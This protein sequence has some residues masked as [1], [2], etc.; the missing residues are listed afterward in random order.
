MANRIPDN[1][2]LQL[3]QQRRRIPSAPAVSSEGATIEPIAGPDITAGPITAPQQSSITSSSAESLINTQQPIPF[4][5]IHYSLPSIPDF[6]A[7]QVPGDLEQAEQFN[8]QIQ[9]LNNTPDVYS[10]GQLRNR[11]QSTFNLNRHSST[12]APTD[13]GLPSEIDVSIEQAN[14]RR[15]LQ[16]Q[17]A[18]VAPS[19]DRGLVGVARSLN[20]GQPFTSASNQSV[21]DFFLNTLGVDVAPVATERE[22]TEPTTMLDRVIAGAVNATSA[23]IPGAAGVIGQLVAPGADD[24]GAGRRIF[25]DAGRIAN[26]RI[27]RRIEEV[28]LGQFLSENTLGRITPGRTVEN[29]A[30]NIRRQYGT[31]SAAINS[32]IQNYTLGIGGFE[33]GRLVLGAGDV[34]TDREG[35]EPFESTDTTGVTSILSRVAGSTE[36]ESI[37]LPTDSSFIGELAN[38]SPDLRNLLRDLEPVVNEAGEIGFNP[39]SGHFGEFGSAGS[40]SGL[41]WLANLPE[42]VVTGALYDIADL[43][44]HVTYDT[45]VG[46]LLGRVSPIFNEQLPVD[47]ARRLDLLGA[48]VGRDYGF[49]Q[50]YTEDRYLSFIGNPGLRFI[51]KPAQIAAGFIAD[52][53]LGGFTDFALTDPVFDLITRGSRR[54]TQNVAEELVE[55]AT[56]V[57]RREV[58]DAV[59]RSVDDVLRRN[60][61]PEQIIERIDRTVNRVVADSAPIDRARVAV[62]DVDTAIRRFNLDSDTSFSLTTSIRRA[63]DAQLEIPFVRPSLVGEVAETIAPLTRRIDDV[64][65]SGERVTRRLRTLDEQVDRIQSLISSQAARR[66]STEIVAPADEVAEQLTLNYEQSLVNVLEEQTTLLRGASSQEI[67][68]YS[69]NLLRRAD[70]ITDNGFIIQENA[71]EVLDTLAPRISVEQITPRATDSTTELLFAYRSDP[72]SLNDLDVFSVRR[73]DQTVSEV[74]NLWGL[75]TPP[76]GDPSTPI[77]ELRNLYRSTSLEQRYPRLLGRYGK[78]ISTNIEAPIKRIDFSSQIDQPYT[79]SAIAQPRARTLPVVEDNV[80]PQI[81]RQEVSRERRRLV[82]LQNRAGR[83]MSE[84]QRNLYDNNVDKVFELEDR[85]RNISSEI[86]ELFA[87]NPDIA[88]EEIVENLP[89]SVRPTGRE[90]RALRDRYAL[91]EH[92]FHYENGILKSMEADLADVD[93]LVK[94]QQDVVARLPQLERYSPANELA[95]RR[96]EGLSTRTATGEVAQPGPDFT[97][98]EL[99]DTRTTTITALQQNPELEDFTVEQLRRAVENSPDLE[100]EPSNRMLVRRAEGG[101]DPDVARYAAFLD[102]DEVFN[103]LQP[104]SLEAVSRSILNQEDQVY[105]VSFSNDVELV[106]GNDA[107]NEITIDFSVGGRFV[108]TNRRPLSV[109]KGLSEMKSFLNDFMKMNP[110]YDYKVTGIAFTPREPSLSTVLE[111]F[112][113]E[114][115]TDEVA[116][117]FT[118]SIGEVYS[119]YTTYYKYGFRLDD[120][121]DAGRRLSIQDYAEALQRDVNQPMT[122]GFNPEEGLQGLRNQPS[123]GDYYHGTK[124]TSLDVPAFSP[125]NELGMGLYLST[126]INVAR[127]HARAIPAEDLVDVGDLTNRFTNQGSIYS[128]AIPNRNQVT[129]FGSIDFEQ[130]NVININLMSNDMINVAQEEF[131]RVIEDLIPEILPRWSSWSRRHRDM[132]EWWNYIRSQYIRLRGVDSIDE[133]TEFAQRIQTSLT[134]IGIDGLQDGNN[135]VVLNPSKISIRPPVVDETSTGSIAEGLLN[136]YAADLDLHNRVNNTTTEAILETDRLA[137]DQYIRNQLADSVAEQE[138]IAIRATRSYNEMADRMERSVNVDRSRNVSIEIDEANRNAVNNYNRVNRTPNLPTEC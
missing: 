76:V 104:G 99:G 113:V 67:E 58:D 63:G 126:D 10:V 88:I 61:L 17:N 122:F 31:P 79:L 44:R 34:A 32:T 109:K 60:Q 92:R 90:S 15:A 112:R 86:N 80:P 54:A 40:L 70:E 45:R 110:S 7:T 27:Q 43:A 106:L 39:F 9:A 77:G 98:P 14:T 59:T 55:T 36:Q 42:G 2:D 131:R 25:R 138:N 128:I 30:R 33:N 50:R 107:F 8:Q 23:L 38:T 19:A 65:I 5:P 18:S 119:K 94:Q 96:R 51:P 95:T 82:S 53:A 83:T 116:R 49:T 26:N 125:T 136:R 13:R 22:E 71:D 135:L 69:Q 114:G 123:V 48:A 35:F 134:D 6:L 89:T 20:E 78:P 115:M 29:V 81:R 16:T 102:E 111:R 24:V 130:F 37:S 129:D 105:P 93:R 47:N 85:L 72:Y 57:A 101:V 74:A 121:S 68:L 3:D 97:I 127:R 91:A 28:G 41:L 4:R 52:A 117:D 11:L 84:I 87:N 108:R 103:G 64:F 132:G 133:Y 62:P 1:N 56:T 137:I 66:N 118:S 21:R 120:G 124:A 75:P 12:L 73:N 100:L 46:R